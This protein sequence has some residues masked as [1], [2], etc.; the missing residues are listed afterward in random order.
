MNCADCG[1][2]KTRVQETVDKGDHVRRYRVCLKCGYSF[3][4]VERVAVY[5]SPRAGYAEV[6]VDLGDMNQQ[7]AGGQTQPAPKAARQERFRRASADDIYQPVVAEAVPHL[8]AWWNEAR[9]SKH[10]PRATWTRRAFNESVSRVY[11]LP[12]KLQIELCRAGAEMGWQALHLSY[13]RKETEL[14]LQLAD[15]L[16][17]DQSRQALEE[18]RAW[19]PAQ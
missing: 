5:I 2:E 3:V 12:P 16:R 4:S 8:L 1:H 7:A 9:W 18:V 6:P 17:N 13:I 14:P 15:G 19:T 10:G 11:D